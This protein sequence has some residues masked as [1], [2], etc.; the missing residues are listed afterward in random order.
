MSVWESPIFVGAVALV[1]RFAV[2]TMN[3]SWAQARA[4]A[5]ALGRE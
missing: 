4:V 5:G 3:Q 1:P 2:V